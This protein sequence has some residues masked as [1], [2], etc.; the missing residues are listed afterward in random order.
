MDEYKF[1]LY[2]IVA[3]AQKYIECWLSEITYT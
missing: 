3:E 1:V 2:N